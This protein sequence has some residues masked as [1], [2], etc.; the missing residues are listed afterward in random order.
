MLRYGY[1]AQPMDFLSRASVPIGPRLHNRRKVIV[2][3]PPLLKQ[4][5]NFLQ[6]VGIGRLLNV[7]V[8]TQFIG[9]LHIPWQSRTAE[10]Y[11]DHL[12]ELW[13]SANPLQQVQS[14]PLWKVQ[15]RQDQ[16]R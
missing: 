3:Q 14:A 4:L 11:D 10:Q 9:L 13:V 8:G 12:L 5:R 6:L 2:T 15:I 1:T 7:S 16:A